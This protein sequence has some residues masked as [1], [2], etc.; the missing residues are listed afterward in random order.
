M[1]A[2]AE[3]SRARL[4]RGTSLVLAICVNGERGSVGEG[5]KEN[6]TETAN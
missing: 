2:L 4:R 5:Q 1:S 6:K 3:D